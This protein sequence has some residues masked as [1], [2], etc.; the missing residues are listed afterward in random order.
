VTAG[1]L[2]H[3]FFTLLLLF[4]LVWLWTSSRARA[5]PT[6]AVFIGAVP[7]LAWLPSFLEQYDNQRFAWITGFDAGKAISV[8]SSFFWNP[9]ALYVR[10]DHVEL[11]PAELAARALVLLVVLAGCIVL[12]RRSD[13]GRLAALLAVLPILLAGLLWI[14]G[15]DI[16]TTRN[17]L[18]AGPFAALALAAALSALPYR[19]ALPATGVA[20]ALV[21]AGLAYE[22]TLAP[23][24]YERL[25]AALVDEGWRLGD[26][27]A[28]YRGAHE[29]SYF[30]SS[31]ALRSPVGW[32]L[33]GHPL[34]RL[35]TV[36]G[37]ICGRAFVVAPVQRPSALV[38]DGDTQEVVDSITVARIACTPGLEKRAL[39]DGAVWFVSMPQA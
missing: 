38:A 23:P 27:V 34:M 18:C 21:V 32:Y 13:E 22:R 31:Y 25:A 11:G 12:A 37:S 16:F 2:T 10:T 3:Y 9:G 6:A 8:Y 19:A 1:L 4:G 26:P 29:L 17:L 24:P 35:P 39:A 7:P 20:L 5:W 28:F 36:E 33:P 30:G 15:A 14:A